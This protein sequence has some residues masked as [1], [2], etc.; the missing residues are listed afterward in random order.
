MDGRFEIAAYRR[1]PRQYTACRAGRGGSSRADTHL[2]EE[3]GI[4]RWFH[5]GDDISKTE[6]STFANFEV[7]STFQHPNEDAPVHGRLGSLLVA[8]DTSQDIPMV[9]SVAISD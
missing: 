7:G 6:P 4:D 2:W 1:A 8:Y 9:A 5:R 3:P